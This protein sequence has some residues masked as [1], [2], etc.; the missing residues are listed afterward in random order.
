MSN[1]DKI[2]FKGTSYFSYMV[3]E[4]ENNVRVEE[5]HELIQKWAN[6]FVA[7]IAKC[8]PGILMTVFKIP[9]EYN[10]KII[11]GK[12]EITAEMYEVDTLNKNIIVTMIL[13]IK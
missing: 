8:P 11:D 7:D 9:D 3:F 10:Q 13:E 5:S 12:Y 6:Q 2:L 4:K 1:K